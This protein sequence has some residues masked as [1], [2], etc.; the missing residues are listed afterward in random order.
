M[1]VLFLLCVGIAFS[2]ML[3][4]LPAEIARFDRW[5]AAE[6][7]RAG[8]PLSWMVAGAIAQSTSSVT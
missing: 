6:L 3:P 8:P 5:A 2:A 7:K 4:G 1:I